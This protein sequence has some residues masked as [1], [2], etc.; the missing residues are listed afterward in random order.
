MAPAAQR[1]RAETYLYVNPRWVPARSLTLALRWDV[2]IVGVMFVQRP[3]GVFKRARGVFAGAPCCQRCI[4]RRR[5]AS[6]GHNSGSP[7]AQWP[8]LSP[9]TPFFCVLNISITNVAAASSLSVAVAVSNTVR[10]TL[11]VKSDRRNGA[12]SDFV[13]VY[14]PGR[15]RKK[16][17]IMIMSATACS[18]WSLEVAATQARRRGT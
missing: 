7:V 1:D 11:K 14:S 2:I 6:V 13:H 5:K 18:S 15:R 16:K 8:I 17:A 9:R 4:M 10:P 12:L 3:I